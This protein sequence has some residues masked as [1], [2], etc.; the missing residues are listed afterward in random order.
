MEQKEKNSQELNE[1]L[2]MMNGGAERCEEWCG[3][4]LTHN[5]YM[6]PKEGIVNADAEIGIVENAKGMKGVRVQALGEDIVICPKDLD[7]GKDNFNYDSANKRLKELNLDTFN[8]KQGLIIAIYIE[9]INAKLVE[10]G[11]DKFSEDWYVSNEL[12]HP[13][14][15]CADYGANYSW[16]LHGDY[17]IFSYRNRF[18][19]YFRSR[20]ALAYNAFKN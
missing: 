9:E 13:V 8:R 10:V 7:G 18:N 16:C 5:D 1:N 2:D 3:R 14:G 4:P 20:P 12:W 15:S 6:Q 17:G 19:G 11:G